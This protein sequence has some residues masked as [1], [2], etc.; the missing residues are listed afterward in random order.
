MN[1]SSKIRQDKGQLFL[2]TD[3]PAR[4]AARRGHATERYALRPLCL[5]AAACVSSARTAALARR[6]LKLSDVAAAAP[7]CMALLTPAQLRMASTRRAAA[8]ASAVSDAKMVWMS[9]ANASITCAACASAWQGS[10][11][12]ALRTGGAHNGSAIGG[13]RGISLEGQQISTAFKFT[14]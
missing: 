13:A 11:A 3:T 2:F 1:V 10:H 5:L 4:A 9:A 7:Y 8:F 12:A 14:V 6:R